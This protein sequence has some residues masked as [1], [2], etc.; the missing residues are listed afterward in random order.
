MSAKLYI[1]TDE[2][3]K[4]L[5]KLVDEKGHN[6]GILIVPALVVEKIAD[7]M[8]V[9]M[10]NIEDVVVSYDMGVNDSEL[11]IDLVDERLFCSEFK[12]MDVLKNA[13]E[14]GDLPVELQA[15]VDALGGEIITNEVKMK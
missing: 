5:D 15:V 3:L 10:E 12:S 7:A 8:N 2:E 13:I 6:N 1:P 9:D 14:N 4:I 11:A